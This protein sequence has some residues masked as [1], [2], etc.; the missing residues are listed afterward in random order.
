M[1]HLTLESLPSDV[2]V[3]VDRLGDDRV[4]L[5]RMG[6]PVAVL[7]GVDQFD[8]EDMQ[9]AADPAFWDMIRQ[10]RREPV[11]STLDQIKAKLTSDEQAGS[12]T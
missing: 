7:V 1:K 9:Y 6:K 4:V 11:A 10:R 3:V 5:T 8:E 12:S 2:A